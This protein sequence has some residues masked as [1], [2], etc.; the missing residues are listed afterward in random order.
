MQGVAIT[1]LGIISGM[2]L[3]PDAHFASLRQL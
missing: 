3:G 2:G 1:G